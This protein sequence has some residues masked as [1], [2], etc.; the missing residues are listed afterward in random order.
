MV[1]FVVLFTSC[2]YIYEPFHRHV[3]DD[4]EEEQ[5]WCLTQYSPFVQRFDKFLNLFHF[6]ALIIIIVAAHIRSNL[7]KTFV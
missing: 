3:M 4:E 5:T 1:L 2:T 7:Q 6:S